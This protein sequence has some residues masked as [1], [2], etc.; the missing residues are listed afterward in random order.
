MVQLTFITNGLGL[1]DAPHRL[2]K[3]AATRVHNFQQRHSLFKE[4]YEDDYEFPLAYQQSYVLVIFVNCLLFSSIVPIISFFAALYFYIKHKVDKYNLIFTYFRKYESGG[5]VKRSVST[6]MFFNMMLYMVTIVTFFGLR[7]PDTF[8]YWFGVAF[9]VLWVVLY[10][11]CLRYW[12][13]PRVQ[14]F[15]RRIR[16]SVKHTLEETG[17]KVGQ[18]LQGLLRRPSRDDALKEDL[19]RKSDEGSPRSESLED[20][21]AEGRKAQLTEDQKSQLRE[22]NRRALEMSYTHPF[23]QLD[24]SLYELREQER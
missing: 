21:L 8:F 6:F 4:P 19:I 9:G 13:T 23:L 22:I 16:V 14:R 7:F 5:R 3:W 20:L 17:Q 24:P 18:N 10:F 2:W 12:N 11:L 1:I 15:F